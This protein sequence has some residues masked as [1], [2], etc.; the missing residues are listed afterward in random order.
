MGVREVVQQHIGSLLE[1]SRHVGEAIKPC[2]KTVCPCGL[3]ADDAEIALEADP[4]GV[5]RRRSA[6][7]AVKTRLWV[8]RHLLGSNDL[9]DVVHELVD[10]WHFVFVLV[11]ILVQLAGIK[12]QFDRFISFDCDYY[13]GDELVIR[14]LV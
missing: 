8:G 14:A 1:F 3:T 9:A 5:G 4:M 6:S 2:K 10:V 13:R 11:D 12:G 7:P